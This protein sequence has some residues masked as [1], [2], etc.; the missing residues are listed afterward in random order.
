MPQSL[1][2]QATVVYYEISTRNKSEWHHFTG[3]CMLQK[4]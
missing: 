4:V 1:H 3:T 2:Q